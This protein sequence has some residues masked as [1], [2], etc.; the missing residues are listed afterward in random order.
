MT[1]KRIAAALIVIVTILLVGLGVAYLLKNVASNNVVP[2]SSGQTALDPPNVIMA[3]SAPG[4][5]AELSSDLYQ[6]QK[7]DTSDAHITYKSSSHDYSVSIPTKYHT[8]FYAKNTSNK[9]DTKTIQDQTTS[10]L[11]SKGYN[12]VETPASSS[13]PVSVTYASQKAVC[14]LTGSGPISDSPTY[15]ALACVDMTGIDQEYTAIEKLLSLY[16][17]SHQLASFTQAIRS[18]VTEDNKSL[19]IINLTEDKSHHSFLFAAIDTNWEYIG[20]LSGT[21]TSSGKYTITPEV[22]TALHN[23]KYGDFL[24]KNIH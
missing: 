18:T 7:D 22:N 8:L 6:Q 5:I 20:D 23:P 1:L 17:A 16:K 4:A 12:K 24:T 21:T 14:Q 2:S 11:L 13:T 15:Y 3:Y 9:D 10:F 19:S